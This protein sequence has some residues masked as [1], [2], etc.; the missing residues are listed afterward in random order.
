MKHILF[1]ANLQ[2]GEEP[3]GGG[4]QTRNQFMLKWFEQHCDVKF[5]DTW[6]KP[7]IV[8][9]LCSLYYAIFNGK[10]QIVI[11]YGSRGALLLMKVLYYLCCKRNIFFFVPGNDYKDLEES[12]N[13]RY[14]R[15]INHILIQSRSKALELMQLGYSNVSYCPNFKLIDYRPKRMQEH[16]VPINFVYVGRLIEEKGIQVMIDAC[17]KIEKK[18]A[19]T[20]YGKETDKYNRLFFEQLGDNRIE[21]KGYINLK[22]KKGLDELAQYDVLLFPTFFEGEGFSGTLIDAFICGL[23]VIAT[24]FNANS[25][26]VQDGENGIIV[27]PKNSVALSEAMKKMIDGRFDLKR[28]SKSSCDS[29]DRYNIN[30]VMGNIFNENL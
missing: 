25:E 5:Y 19:L 28:M 24:D 30:V 22:S 8:S 10:R 14:W 9:L 4:V 21:Y 11:S 6:K 7:A 1:L 2:Y 12:K 20:I 29:A 17:Q 18:F 13:K 15:K 27:P 26:I 3:T 23:P 16:K